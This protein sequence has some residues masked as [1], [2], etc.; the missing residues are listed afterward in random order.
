M[1]LEL[2]LLGHA[3][4]VNEKAEA[5]AAHNR[6][7]EDHLDA[8]EARAG[9]RTIGTLDVAQLP[10]PPPAPPPFG[11]WAGPRT[12]ACLAWRD[13]ARRNL[14]AGVSPAGMFARLHGNFAEQVGDP[15]VAAA[16]LAAYGISEQ[17]VFNYPLNTGENQ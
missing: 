5:Q 11:E 8:V 16:T 6:R 13:A 12:E 15:A 2:I 1:I 17:G 7:V 3:L 10:P 14:D 9:L 4:N